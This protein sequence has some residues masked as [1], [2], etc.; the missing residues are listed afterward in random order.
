M[1]EYSSFADWIAS[2]SHLSTFLTLLNP[3]FPTSST[4]PFSQ[5]RKQIHNRIVQDLDSFYESIEVNGQKQLSLLKEYE[6]E[7]LNISSP[8]EFARKEDA[9][10]CRVL[11]FLRELLLNTNSEIISKNLYQIMEKEKDVNDLIN[12]FKSNLIDDDKVCYISTSFFSMNY[13]ATKD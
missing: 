2:H 9:F 3:S 5:R 7:M 4:Q 13:S 1:P 8:N 12:L 10:M 6:I 11:R